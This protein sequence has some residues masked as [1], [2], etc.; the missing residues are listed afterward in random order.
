[1][2]HVTPWGLAGVV[3]VILYGCGPLIHPLPPQLGDETNAKIDDSWNAALEP[4]DRHDRQTWLDA[5]FESYGYQ[6]GV[7]R[8]EFRSEKKWSGGL[9]VM[10]VKCDRA[11]PHDDRFVLTVRNHAG[12]VLRTES[13]S[14]ADVERT[15]NELRGLDDP[16]VLNPTPEQVAA[17]EAAARE[18]IT[19]RNRARAVIMTP[20]S[21]EQIRQGP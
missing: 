10:E 17:R 18:L 1:M 14:R 8:L 13:Y 9:V 4:I 11:K 20:V 15:N 19:R 2:R 6:L 12:K 21:E 16:L 7:D 3:V 5:M